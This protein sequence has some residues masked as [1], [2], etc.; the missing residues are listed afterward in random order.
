MLLFLSEFCKMAVV[1][2]SEN[3][4]HIINFR[5]KRLIVS[6]VAISVAVMKSYYNGTQSEY[7]IRSE[8]VIFPFQ[9]LGN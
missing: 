6:R 8:T 9:K 4:T 1:F 2:K 7:E 5:A 3:T